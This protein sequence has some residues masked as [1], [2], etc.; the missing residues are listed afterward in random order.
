MY[1]G[2]RYKSLYFPF[3]F[4]CE[5]KTAL[6]K[7]KIRS[8]LKKNIQSSFREIELP[9]LAN[10]ECKSAYCKSDDLETSVALENIL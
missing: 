5:P 6:Q 9:T 4:C 10:T 1:R 7:I 2:R 8:I 3:K